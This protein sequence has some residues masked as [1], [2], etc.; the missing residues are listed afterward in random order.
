VILLY[1]EGEDAA[2]IG[3]L[4]GLSASNVATKIH[5]INKVLTSRSKEDPMDKQPP[6]D[7]QTLWQSQP[8]DPKQ[9]SSEEIRDKATRFQRR[10]RFRNLREYV[11]AVFVLV[12]FSGYAW[13]ASTWL[14]KSGPALIVVG[15]LYIMFQLY[16]RAASLPVAGGEGGAGVTESCAQFHRRELERQRDLLRTVW[17]WYLGPLVPGLLVM[18]VDGFIDA[19]EKGGV[20]IV[21]S[22]GSA[23]ITVLVFLGVWWL[24]AVGAKKL[25]REIDALGNGPTGEEA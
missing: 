17:Q 22:L 1:L 10:V 15:T 12:I 11:A 8:V 23:P 16:T 3:D 24:N 19:G 4:T 2:D 7:L 20:A 9:F 5:R 18:F 13:K 21:A 25:Q 6:T 14:S